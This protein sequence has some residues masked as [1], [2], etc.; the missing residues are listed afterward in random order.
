M[1][2]CACACVCVLCTYFVLLLLDFVRVLSAICINCFVQF[3][4]CFCLLVKVGTLFFMFYSLF[5]TVQLR[6]LYF[7]FGDVG[8]D[9]FVQLLVCYCVS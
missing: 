8:N 1:R 4:V 6:V 3:I 9:V 2:L 5:C 7:W